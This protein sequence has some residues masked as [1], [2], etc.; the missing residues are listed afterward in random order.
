MDCCF[1]G[2]FGDLVTKDDG[3]VDLGSLLGAEGGVVL[4]SSRSLEN[5]FE[6][7]G[8]DLSIYTRYLVEGIRTGAADR[9]GDG[10]VSVDELHQFASIATAK[11][12][13]A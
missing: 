2:A 3:D 5:S 11:A 12:V 7:K 9:D 8:S 10:A 6:Q 1:S 4:T 13:K